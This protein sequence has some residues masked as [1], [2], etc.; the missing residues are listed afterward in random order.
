MGKKVEQEKKDKKTKERIMPG[1][2]KDVAVGIDVLVTLL[3][4]RL[5]EML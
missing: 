4:K 5:K 2:E 1:L 3:N